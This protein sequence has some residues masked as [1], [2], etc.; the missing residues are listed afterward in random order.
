MKPVARC[1]IRPVFT[2]AS[3]NSSFDFFLGESSRTKDIGQK[4][5]ALLLSSQSKEISKVR[6]DGSLSVMTYYL[7]ERLNSSDGVTLKTAFDYLKPRVVKYV[8]DEFPGSPQTP[9]LSN[10]VG[11]VFLRP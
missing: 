11:T 3:T 10:S 9:V 7:I 2:F 5:A 6:R 4:D 8:D 1:S